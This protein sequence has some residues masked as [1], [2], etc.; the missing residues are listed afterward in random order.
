MDFEFHDTPKLAKLRNEVR[1]WLDL[2]IPMDFEISDNPHDVLPGSTKYEFIREARRKLGAKGWLASTWPKEYGGGGLS[3]D[4]AAVVD[5]EVAQRPWSRFG[6]G[7]F[8]V[9][10]LGF[11][12]PQL[13]MMGTEEQKKR[14]GTPLLRGEIIAWQGYSEPDCGSDAASVKTTAI[15]DGDDYVVN[16]SKI[17]LGSQYDN[18]D[19][20]FVVAV[21]D[22]KAPRRR[23]IGLFLVP[24]GLPGISKVR[25][26][27]MRNCHTGGWHIF[28]ENVRV[29]VEYLIGGHE[30]AT[31]G[32]RA[33]SA[34]S[35]GTMPPQINL[36]F[37]VRDHNQE[38]VL[39][40]C[41]ETK[42]DGQPL[43]QDSD[44]REALVE[45]EI[46]LELNRLFAM[47]QNWLAMTGKRLVGYEAAQT[48]LHR[49][50]VT[51]IEQSDAYNDILGPAAL[52][53]EPE[54]ALF[55]GNIEY[56]HFIPVA[57]AA[58]GTTAE[59]DSMLM[60]R[61]ACRIGD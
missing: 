50:D 44:V 49:K 27:M 23:N 54:W 36:G 40:Y 4:E 57:H 39:A 14:F 8:F 25:V 28:F 24:V 30:N 5:S 43:S 55:E 33:I 15:R 3:V 42:H 37:T 26:P 47:R 10:S 32:W 6:V 46:Q 2:N 20:I 12:G 16:G 56:Q 53:K 18:A 31:N 11:F 48:H 58:A 21:T 13:L 9:S 38:F 61:W 1:A 45:V 35:S 60:A 51:A 19:Y 29:P 17:W 59:V 52:M 34:G 7:D 41:R 22:P